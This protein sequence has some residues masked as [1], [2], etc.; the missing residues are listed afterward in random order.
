MSIEHDRNR[1]DEKSPSS[2]DY[3]VVLGKNIGKNS[4][5]EDIRIRKQHLSIDSKIN[6]I[7]AALSY[8]EAKKLNPNTTMKLIFSSGKTAGQDRPSEAKAMK[9]Y[10]HRKFIDI[11][12]KA[13]ILE[14]VSVDT[15]GNAEEVGKLLKKYNAKNPAL[16]T[17]GYHLPGA[18]ET[19]H[20]YG[21]DIQ[22]GIAAEQVLNNYQRQPGYLYT[23]DRLF[24]YEKFVHEWSRSSRIRAEKRRELGR[25]I[26][27]KMDKR[28]KTIRFFT[29]RRSA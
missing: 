28:A 17:V 27:L 22:H 25:R 16:L 8:R 15:P 5:R 18:L 3:I 6:A 4:T 9:D 1:E 14:E 7:A 10:L 11:P 23:R 13:I 24:P 21:V 19:F 26:L 2:Y 12:E 20:N 29:K